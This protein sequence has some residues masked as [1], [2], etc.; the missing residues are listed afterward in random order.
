MAVSQEARGFTLIELLVVIAIIGL[1]SSIVLSSLT[2]A[3]SKARDAKRLTDMHS[4]QTAL[5]VYA[6][7]HAGAYPASVGSGS[8]CWAWWEGGNT[9]N[10]GGWLTALV[11]D[12]E[13]SAVPKE[14]FIG[15]CS[16]RYATF[17]SAG[18]TQCG[19]QS[20]TYAALYML[21]E[22]PTPASCHP[23]CVAPWGWYEAQG[24][25]PNGC[26]LVV[27]L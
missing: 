22:N 11:T 13:F 5:E 7:G 16:Y 25:D 12:G 24:S 27:P 17:S 18:S 10:A 1:L 26:L 23:S 15:G 8:G 19:S 6:N 3:R 20:G 14:N 21:L 9:V 2:S 4:I